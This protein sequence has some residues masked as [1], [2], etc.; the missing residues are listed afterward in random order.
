MTKGSG[1]P[2]RKLK[3]TY[4]SEVEAEA[5]AE[6]EIKKFEAQEGFTAEFPDGRL[7]SEENPYPSRYNSV[8]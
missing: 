7:P 3:Q 1:K 8:I 5:A 4:A 2:E 6:Q